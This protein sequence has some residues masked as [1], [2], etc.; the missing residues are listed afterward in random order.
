MSNFNESWESNKIMQLVP[1][2]LY[3]LLS[4]IVKRFVIILRAY[5]EISKNK[6]CHS[7]S[8]ASGIKHKVTRIHKGLIVSF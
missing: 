2:Q 5:S 6:K 4:F 3:Y 8:D 1:H 7:Q